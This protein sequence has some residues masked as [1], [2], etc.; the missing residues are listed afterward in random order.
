MDIYFCPCIL[1]TLNVCC[2]PVFSEYGYNQNDTL[3]ED[4]VTLKEFVVD[5]AEG[6]CQL[7]I[8]FCATQVAAIYDKKQ[9]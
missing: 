6:Q 5:D 4:W 3:Y 1:F 7:V 9:K 8:V 2:I